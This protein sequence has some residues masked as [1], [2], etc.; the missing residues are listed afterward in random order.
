MMV[1]AIAQFAHADETQSKSCVDVQIGEARSYSCINAELRRIATGVHAPPALPDVRADSPAP[2][3]GTFS[4]AA[5]RERLG[6]AFG[7]SL[8]P[9]RPEPAYQFPP[10]MHH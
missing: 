5:T 2:A 9:Q 3:T 7:N 4:Q 8:V 1:I 6:N 10:F